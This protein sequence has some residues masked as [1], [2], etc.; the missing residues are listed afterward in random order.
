[1]YDDDGEPIIVSADVHKSDDVDEPPKRQ[2]TFTQK[3]LEY[4]LQTKF[5]RL[6]QLCGALEKNIDVCMNLIDCNGDETEINKQYKRWISLYDD[7]LD[8]ENNY[9]ELLEDEALEQH[10]DDWLDPRLTNFRDFKTTME[11]WITKLAKQRIAQTKP[12]SAMMEDADHISVRS[13]SS[14]ASNKSSMIALEQKKAEL[15][16]KTA[17][18]KKKRELAEA[19]LQLQLQEDELQIEEEQ[20]IHDAQSKVLCA[21]DV[22]SDAGSNASAMFALVKRLNR[23]KIEIRKFSGSP[24]EYR[25][26]MRQLETQVFVNCETDDDKLSFLDQY[27]TGEPNKIV[28]GYSYL[29]ATKGLK[30]TLDELEDR[31]GNADIVVDAFIAKALSW[32][33]IKSDNAKGLD[34]FSIFLTE[35]EQAV[36]DV[37]SLKI[38]EYTENFRRIV[39]K[40]PYTL[41]D[42]WRNIA[43]EKREHKQRPVFHDLVKFVRKEAKKAIDPAFG[44]D[45]MKDPT[46]PQHMSSRSPGSFASKLTSVKETSAATST[47]A[48]SSFSPVNRQDA[49]PSAFTS[50]CLHCQGSHSLDVCA[51]FKVLTFSEKSNI[52]KS[53]G[54]CFGCLRYGHHRRD[55]RNKAMCKVCQGRHPTIMHISDRDRESNE[56]AIINKKADMEKSATVV[57]V[58]QNSDAIVGTMAIIPVKIRKKGTTN[59]VTTYAFIDTGSNVSFCLEN[60]MHQLGV[61]GKRV[62]L[63]MDTMGSPFTMHTYEVGDLEILDLREEHCLPLPVMYTK[64]RMPVTRGHIPTT[65]DIGKWPHLSD[66]VLPAVDSDIGLL[67]GN[68]VTD[69]CAPLEVRTGPLGSPHLTRSLLGWIPWNVL[70]EG[71]HS[72]VAVVNRADVTAIEMIQELKELNQ[73][74]QRSVNMEFPELLTND[75]RE[76]SMEDKLFLQ[77]VSSSQKVVDGHYQFQLPFREQC[78]SLPDNK[79]LARQ[80]LGSLKKKL[81]QNPEFQKDYNVFMQTLTDRGFA[82]KVP[83]SELDRSD[84]KIWYLPHHGVYHPSKKKLRVVFDCSAQ[85]HGVSLNDKLLQGPDLTNHLIAVLL[86]FRQEPYAITA[87][88]EKMFYQIYVAPEDRDCL[89]YF[90]WPG[91]YLT[92]EPQVHRM[93][94]HLF[95]AASSPSCSSYALKQTIQDHKGEYDDNVIESALKNFYVDDYLCSVASE[96]EAINLI[97]DVTELCAQ[98]GFHLTKWIANSRYVMESVPT[99]ERSEGVKNLDF[100]TLPVDRALGV[101]WNVNDDTL[102]FMIKTKTCIPT[103]RNVLSV[104][105]SVYDPLGIASPFILPA[106]ILL[107]ELCRKQLT[108]DEKLSGSDLETWLK[109]MKN[110]PLVENIHIPRCVRPRFTEFEPTQR[111]ELHHF[112]DA[113]D[114]GYGSVSYLRVTTNNDNVHC[115]LLFAKSRVSPLKKVTTPRLELAA[116]TLAVKLN[117]MLLSELQ[118]Q[119]HATYF[120]TDSMAVM[121]YIANQSTRFQTFVANRLAVIHEG[122]DVK[123]WKFIDGKINPADIAS[124]GICI[125]DVKK[126]DIWLNG[127]EFLR[128]PDNTWS[129]SPEANWQLPIDDPEVKKAMTHAGV[130]IEPHFLEKLMT[131]FSNLIKLRRTVGWILFYIKC[132]KSRVLSKSANSKQLDLSA[133]NK[134]AS[135]HVLPISILQEA[136]AVMIKHIQKQHYVKELTCL[137]NNKPV[138][139]TSN[140]YKLDT[141]LKDGIMRVG[142]RLS[143][144]SLQY[145][146]KHQILLPGE[147]AFSKLVLHD[148]HKR[149]GHQGKNAVIAELRQNYWIPRATSIIKTITS[150]C[151]TC[152]RYHGLS[153][154]QKMAEL[155]EDRVTPDKPPFSNLGMDYF[156]PIEVRRGRSS[157]KRYGVIFTCSTSRAIHLEIAASLT[158]D[159]CINAIRR[160]VARRGPVN[161]IRSDNGTN[162]VGAEAELRREIQNWNQSDIGR[163]LEQLNIQ[164][165]FNPPSASHHGGFW[166]RMIRSVRKIIYCLLRDQPKILDDEA[167]HTVMCE[168]EYI[169]NNRPLTTSSED[170]SELEMLTPNHIILMKNPKGLPPGIFCDSDNYARRRWRQIQYLANVFWVRWQR[171]YIPLLQKRQK[172]IQPKKNVT[173]GD[174]VLVMD[175]LPRN[176]WMLGRVTEV[177]RD[178]HGLVRVVTVQT[179]TSTLQRPVTKLCLLLEIDD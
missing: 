128:V 108:W 10:K 160:M 75:K 86:R 54:C 32:P 22:H 158:T 53:K 91:G 69:V 9:S 157:I 162:I 163:T 26:F 15:V 151:V 13:T 39:S 143:R 34:E 124:R 18:L 101:T 43:H 172:W 152:R 71:S 149:T 27:T 99:Q 87:D 42:K 178:R 173:V 166:E 177:H 80:R 33:T 133:Q 61:N 44:R 171:E 138:M 109:W 51:R 179:K 88:I 90:W 31:Y 12:H 36:K 134:L 165:I 48:G 60:L 106:R 30:L 112:A 131:K 97:K 52:L 119:I 167:L 4:T 83:E 62:K 145:N 89:R 155:P 35:C 24:L 141:F 49:R 77:K 57:S 81:T 55:C 20:A 79:F 19:K 137:E 63:S 148:L 146:A 85:Y 50:P 147:S 161:I 17:H 66:I 98:G 93:T 28:H 164:W 45:A 3:G 116:A 150:K 122:S 11:N 175:N 120:W 46:R 72:C 113:C 105:G 37:D 111:V 118:I 23:P 96:H 94:V 5:K 82:E 65:E 64:D 103:R 67:L 135:H 56:S 47:A 129:D 40:L 156:G 78:P 41:H 115:S 1:M 132:L 14:R 21:S 130:H 176:M 92:D 153:I 102:G 2:R 114:N 29:N 126:T 58:C 76:H 117:R 73:T 159:S 142:G 136:D 74:Y 8:V 7:F 107:Q 70:R 6:N 110:L 154:T 144:S 100:D 123:Q 168:V 140:V 59:S 16:V 139:R 169:L 127:P 84:N 104:I 95:G 25:R 125:T 170:H 68:N 38:L 174:V 121:R